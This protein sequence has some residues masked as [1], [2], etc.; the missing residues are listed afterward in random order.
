MEHCGLYSELFHCALEE[1]AEFVVSDL[2]NVSG[3]HP[4]DGCAGNGVG[5]GSAGY[6]FYPYFLK[7][8]PDAVPGFHVHMLHAPKRQMI[9]FQEGIVRQDCQ[10]IRKCVAYS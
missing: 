4:E 8:V 3:W 6:V 5:S 9:L 7:G 10:N 1:L 2:A